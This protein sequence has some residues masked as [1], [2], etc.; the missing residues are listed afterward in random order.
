MSFT[1]GPWTVGNAGRSVIREVPGLSDAYD[2]YTVAVMTS[3]SLVP[4]E[5]AQANAHRIVTAVNAF[6]DMKAALKR[7]RI[8]LE[9]AKIVI[10]SYKNASAFGIVQTLEIVE[11][12][13]TKAQGQPSV[14]GGEVG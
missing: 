5:E 11:S 4:V 1:P 13:I 8:D 2:H 10:E 3:H 6:D 7:A 12:A 9:A 14:S